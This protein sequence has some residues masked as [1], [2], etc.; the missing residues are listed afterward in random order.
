MT[1]EWPPCPQHLQTNPSG[2]ASFLPHQQRNTYKGAYCR[3]VNGSLFKGLPTAPPAAIPAVIPALHPPT[4]SAQVF[5]SPLVLPNP[6]SL[7][8]SLSFPILSV[9]MSPCPSQSCQSQCP[10]PPLVLPNPVSLNVSLSFPIL[11]VS[12][13]PCPSQS[14]QS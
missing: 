10:P 7:N 2:T 4:V 8:V 3:P 1:A 5:K 6:I 13:S 12:M 9:S 14:C 11:S